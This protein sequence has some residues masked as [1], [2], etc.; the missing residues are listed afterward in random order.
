M[1]MPHEQRISWIRDDVALAGRLDSLWPEWD[2]V[3]ENGLAETLDRESDWSGWEAWSSDQKRSRL[4]QT[5]DAWYPAEPA[6]PAGQVQS[7]AGGQRLPVD[8]VGWIRGDQALVARLGAVWPGWD[9]PGAGGLVAT[10]DQIPEWGGWDT[11]SEADRRS[12]LVQTLDAWYPAEPA[13]E[14]PSPAAPAVEPLLEEPAAQ[15]LSEGIAAVLAEALEA[16]PEAAGLSPEEISDLLTKVISD[17]LDAL[18][19]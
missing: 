14:E 15:E 8:R 1:T 13:A 5:L 12:Y 19:G 16:I 10:L 7:A 3:G 4:G 9:D 2:S 18:S 6:E 17:E 11:W